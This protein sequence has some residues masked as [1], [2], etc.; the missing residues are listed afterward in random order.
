LG[1]NTT[2]DLDGDWQS[3]TMTFATIKET[4]FSTWTDCDLKETSQMI[5]MTIYPF[6]PQV[7]LDEEKA[8]VT[9]KQDEG[10]D[11]EVKTEKVIPSDDDGVDCGIE[12]EQRRESESPFVV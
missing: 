6:V 1:Y 2:G 7:V 12:S 9:A 3:Y 4:C 8:K 10:S 11:E 5:S